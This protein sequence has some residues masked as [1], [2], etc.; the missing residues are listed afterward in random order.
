MISDIIVNVL[1][2]VLWQLLQYVLKS[3]PFSNWLNVLH[4]E[5]LLSTLRKRDL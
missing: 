1:S 3:E 2:N 4:G 5:V